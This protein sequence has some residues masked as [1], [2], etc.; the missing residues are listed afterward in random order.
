MEIVSS[1]MGLSIRTSLVAI[2]SLESREEMLNLITNAC[3]SQTKIY[4]LITVPDM[5][6]AEEENVK[7][8]QSEMISKGLYFHIMQ[9]NT[10]EEID[11][12]DIFVIRNLAILFCKMRLIPWKLKNIPFGDKPTMVCNIDVQENADG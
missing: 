8:F 7:F 12:V 1:R 9:F 10:K 6:L 11:E 3:Q 5:T 4:S 2:Q